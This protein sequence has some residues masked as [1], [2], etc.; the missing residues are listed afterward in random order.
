M[1]FKWSSQRAIANS[2]VVRSS[3]VWLVVVPLSAKLL[4]SLDEVI[5]LTIFSGRVSI[6]TILPFSWQLLFFAAV[7]FTIAGLVYSIFCPDLVKKYETHTEF[8]ND[9]KSRLQINYSLKSF[10]FDNSKGTL[11]SEYFESVRKYFSTYSKLSR[12]IDQKSLNKQIISY[13]EAIDLNQGKNSDAFYFVHEL[14]D[15]HNQ[16]FIMLSFFLYI[17]GFI[18]IAIIGLQNVFYVIHTFV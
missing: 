6:E 4:S 13:V 2:K 1:N 14:A 5:D 10:T 3:A 8:N 15:K 16:Y 12:S 11:K 17:A 18:S 7:F 9:G